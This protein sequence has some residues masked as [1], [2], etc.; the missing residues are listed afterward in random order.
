MSNNYYCLL[1]NDTES[2][3]LVNNNLNYDTAIKVYKQGVPRLLEL[4]SK[5][6]IKTTFFITGEIVE[7]I[8]GIVKLI[9]DCGHEI[10]CHGYSHEV[11]EAFDIL[12][13]EVQKEHLLKTKKMLE[14]LSGQ[15]VLS[16]RAPA[17]R[18]NNNTPKA[19]LETGYKIDSSIASQRFD[20]FLS[21]GSIKKLNRF[22]APRRPYFTSIKSLSKP[23]VTDL[24]EIPISALIFPYIGTTL[25]VF[26]KTTRIF[27]KILTFESKI[28]FKPIN[29]LTH[30]NEF[31]DE[32][33]TDDKIKPRTKNFITYLLADKFRYHLKLKNLGLNGLKLYEE[34]IKYLSKEKFKFVT[35]KEFRNIL[36]TGEKI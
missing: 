1:T 22:F 13:F 16:F 21:F 11:N 9:A 15:E 2:T 19:L 7:K 3:S 35:M 17:L 25:R 10:G 33:K 4:Y 27:R 32:E 28:T 5:Y 18:V 30:P 26:P 8:A 31:I 14:D 36:I 12:P 34:E 23:G 24:L 6:N 20:F 29:F